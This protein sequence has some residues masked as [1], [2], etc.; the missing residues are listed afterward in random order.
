MPQKIITANRLIDGEVVWL[1][2]DGDWVEA[3]AAAAIFDAAAL[4]VGM[5][6]A[7]RGVAAGLVVDPLAIDVVL[8]GGAPVPSRLR[9]RI[10]AFGPTVHPD[11]GK[12]ADGKGTHP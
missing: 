2:P 4:E 10:R 3:V 8:R 6:G 9:E 7:R 12:Q 11:Y 1:G 5:E